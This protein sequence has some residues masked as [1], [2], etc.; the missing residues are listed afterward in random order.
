[1]CKSLSQNRG[2]CALRLS[3]MSSVSDAIRWVSPFPSSNQQ[4]QIMSHRTEGSILRTRN[5]SR[6][7][8]STPDRFPRRDIPHG[9]ALLQESPTPTD[10]MKT[11]AAPFCA[12]PSTQN[13][14]RFLLQQTPQKTKERLA[15]LNVVAL[16]NNDPHF[17][18]GKVLQDRPYS[19]RRHI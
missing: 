10:L 2:S 17:F 16:R 9:T 1:M 6:C 15:L 11:Q 3:V 5:G 4:E 18:F 13:I 14:L 7:L 8:L 12:M 19:Q